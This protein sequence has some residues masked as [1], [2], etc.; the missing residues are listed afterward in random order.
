MVFSCL[1]ENSIFEPENI[2]RG[3]CAFQAIHYSI[4][5]VLITLL[6]ISFV[7]ARTG[8][9]MCGLQAALGQTAPS[10]SKDPLQAGDIGNFPELPACCWVR[11]ETVAAGTGLSQGG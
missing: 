8:Q 5:T 4:V 7:I 3:T 1:R 11:S 10:K 2:P 6:I 9:A